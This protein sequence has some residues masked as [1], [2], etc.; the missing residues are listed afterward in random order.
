ME[1]IFRY[2]LETMDISKDN[3]Q[4]MAEKAL[5]PGKEDTIMTLAERL[6]QEGEQKGVEKGRQEERN[7][8]FNRLLLKRFGEIRDPHIQAR[9]Q[10]ASPDQINRWFDRALEA[11]SID[12]VIDE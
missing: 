10:N 11:R 9:L 12:E 3:L 2:M 6:R 5:T 7:D 4:E 1:V 8:L